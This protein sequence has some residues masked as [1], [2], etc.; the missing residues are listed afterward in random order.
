MLTLRRSDERAHFEH[1]WLDTRHT[2][3]FGSYH[4]PAHMGFRA[5]RVIN[6]DVVAPGQGFGTHPHKDMEIITWVLEGALEHRD[7]MGNGEVLRPG[8]AQVMSAG[9]GISHSEF[10]AS[11]NEPVHLLQIWILPSEKG[12]RPGYQQK[13]FADSPGSPLALLA[14]PDAEQGSLKIHQHARLYR[15]L[16]GAGK[17]AFMPL[18]ARRAAWVQVTRGDLGVNGTQM[19]AGDG[20]A[21]EGGNRLTFASKQGAEALLFDLA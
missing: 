7:S 20:A 18:G 3:S 16:L 15:L 9:T 21:I 4:D 14:S 6:E 17:D 8:E 10:N 19:H 13:I 11:K 1:G 5:L 12:L 2:F